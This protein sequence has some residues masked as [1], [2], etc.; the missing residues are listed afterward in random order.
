MTIAERILAGELVGKNRPRPVSTI[1]DPKINALERGVGI[2]TFADGSSLTAT[3]TNKSID[4]DYSDDA[5]NTSSIPEHE[6]AIIGQ[7][8]TTLA[9]FAELKIPL[10]AVF[11][12]IVEAYC[13]TSSGPFSEF[14][15]YVQESLNFDNERLTAALETGIYEAS[16]V[17]G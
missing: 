1:I 5:E 6:V 16:P 17:N 15:N 10:P 3:L 14:A 8:E 13:L 2:F 9:K 7:L 4:P 11:V 12:R